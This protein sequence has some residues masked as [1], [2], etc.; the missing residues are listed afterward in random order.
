MPV[1]GRSHLAPWKMKLPKVPKNRWKEEI[2]SCLGLSSKRRSEDG[3]V[4]TVVV[5]IDSP[6]SL[7]RTGSVR[8]GPVFRARRSIHKLGSR[9][10]CCNGNPSDRC[11]S[12]YRYLDS[13]PPPSRPRFHRYVPK[14]TSH[15]ELRGSR[16]NRRAVAASW[17]GFALAVSGCH[18]SGGNVRG[19]SWHPDIPCG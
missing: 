15:D 1:H 5:T 3:T 2:G 13:T 4:R 8:T 18:G 14:R 7:R 17:T 19:A 11:S 16:L 12:C 9:M 6:C 10:G